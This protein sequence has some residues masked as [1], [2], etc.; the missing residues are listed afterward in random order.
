[1]IQGGKVVAGHRA[2]SLSSIVLSVKGSAYRQ[3]KRL[4]SLA[5]ADGCIEAGGRARRSVDR[6][7]IEMNIPIGS[8]ESVS[9]GSGRAHAAL[10]N[11][12]SVV[13]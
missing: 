5:A 12:H 2:S 10:P 3:H 13:V 6:S 9:V 7:L 8:F 1:V 4:R 11:P